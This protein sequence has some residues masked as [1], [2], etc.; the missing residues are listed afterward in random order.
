MFIKA[1]AKNFMYKVPTYFR[2]CFVIIIVREES[3]IM[4]KFRR[5]SLSK[6]E[7][8]AAIFLVFLR[9]NPIAQRA[10]YR[11][12]HCCYRFLHCCYRFLHCCYRFLHCCYRFLHCCYR[13]LHCVT[14]FCTVLG[15][16]WD[17]L[18]S[19]QP[20]T[21]QKHLLVYYYVFKCT[22]RL[23]MQVWRRH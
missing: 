8:S 17:Q 4:L 7:N 10:Y 12:L 3:Q 13:F 14:D 19:N 1:M 21:A 18:H 2:V 22:I 5:K 15:D 6:R 16:V 11:F 20:I 9:V 23:I